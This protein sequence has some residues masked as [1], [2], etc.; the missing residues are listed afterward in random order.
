MGLD[1]YAEELIHNYEHPD[2]KRN[3][4]DATVSMSEENISCGD[5]ITVHLKIEKKTVADISFEGE[6]CVISMGTA[7]ILTKYLKGKT[8]VDIEK[9]SKDDLLELIAIEPGPVRM[10]CATLALRAIK[11]AVL[12]YEKKPIDVATKEL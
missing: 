12:D 10:H 2:N 6:G 9:M 11:R 1:I 4:K 7:N 3:M 5:E 8:L